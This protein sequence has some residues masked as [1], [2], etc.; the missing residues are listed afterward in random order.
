M[1]IKYKNQEQVLYSLNFKIIGSYFSF[2]DIFKTV[3]S[4]HLLSNMFL[5]YF[6][7]LPLSTKNRSYLPFLIVHEKYIKFEK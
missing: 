3:E 2:L 6:F 7:I 1:L 4:I 5:F